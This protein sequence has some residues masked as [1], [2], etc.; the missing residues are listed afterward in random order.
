MKSRLDSGGARPLLDIASCARRGPGRRDHLSQ[1]QVELIQRTVSRA[2]EVMVKVLARGATSTKSVGAHLAYLS[3]GGELEIETDDGER[4]AGQGTEKSLIEEWD[5]D[6]EEHRT[7]TNLTPSKDRTPPRLVHKLLFSMPPGTPPKKVLTA[8]KNFAREEFALKHRYAMVLHTDEPHPHVHVVVKAMSEDGVRLNIR[9]ETLRRW[10]S[11][12]AAHLR[13]L[14]VPAN[15]T[16]RAVRAESRPPLR[17][18]VYRSGQRGE[19]RVLNERLRNGS[20][21]DSRLSGSETLNETWEVVRNG[22]RSVEELLHESGRVGLAAQVA[23]FVDRM[24]PPR[25]AHQIPINELVQRRVATPV[26]S[27]TR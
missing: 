22:W 12:F 13:A 21:Q 18:A 17:D 14:G 8:V 6:V 25:A 26:Q 5:L 10:R 9:K 19:S 23:A 2:P 1:A 15:A 4:L 24:R 16:E 7:R 20:A 11:D 3:R 27:P